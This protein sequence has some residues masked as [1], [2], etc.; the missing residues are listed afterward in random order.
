MKDVPFKGAFISIGVLP[1]NEI[2]KALGVEL[3]DGGFV[4]VDR[5]L[6]TNRK[7]VYAAGDINGGIQQ[8]I[9]ACGEGAVAALSAYEDIR[10]PYWCEMEK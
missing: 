5:H 6:R 8:A 1:N 9:V 2:A 3:D 10:N 4:K 7:M